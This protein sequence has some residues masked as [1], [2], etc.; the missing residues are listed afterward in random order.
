ML[1]RFFYI[2]DFLMQENWK[3]IKDLVLS[4]LVSYMS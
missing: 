3:M 2:Y 4:S 1:K